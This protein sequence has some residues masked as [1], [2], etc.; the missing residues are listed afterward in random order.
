MMFQSSP[1]VPVARS[2]AEAALL[3]YCART[4]LDDQTAEQIRSLL[5]EDIDWVYL[6]QTARQHGVLP[7]VYWHLNTIGPEVVPETALHQLRHDFY[8]NATHNLFL[9]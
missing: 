7:L 6:L 3:I 5:L 4:S 9:T 8:A 1:N 2:K